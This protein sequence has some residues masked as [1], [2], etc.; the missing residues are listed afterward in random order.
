MPDVLSRPRPAP[1][2][3]PLSVPPREALRRFGLTLLLGAGLSAC[4]GEAG[5]SAPPPVEEGLAPPLQ[6]QTAWTA[7]F[8]GQNLGGWST[9]LPSRGVDSDPEGVFRVADG[10]LRVLD[11]APTAGNREYGYLLTS[12]RYANYRL[13]LQYRWD[14]RKFAPRLNEPRDS[15]VLYHVTGPNTL[16]PSSAEFQI[17]EGATGDLWGLAGTNFT[18]TVSDPGARELKHDPFGTPVTTQEPADGYRRMVRADGVR[19][20]AGWNTLELVVSGDQATQIVNGQV[21]AQATELRAPG[22]ASLTAGRI[23]LQAE[24]AAVS[25]REIELRPLA[26]LTPPQGARVLLGGASTPQSVGADWLDR[27]GGEVRWPVQGGVTTVRPSR[28]PRDTNDIQTRDT[29]GDFHLHLEFRLPATRAGLGEQDRANSGV[30]LQG[31]YEVQILDSF[32]GALAGQN[33]LGAIYGQH[34]ASTNAA[35]P[36][37][38]WQSYDIEFR[39]ARWSGGQKTEDARATVW[40]NGEKVQDDVALSGPTMLGAP[41]ADT[42]GPI[43]LQDH[44]SG[45]SFRNIWVQSGRSTP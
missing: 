30:Y 43:V 44:G 20:M 33:D 31:R 3:L 26:Y 15:G 10:E 24:G 41:E 21:A 4:A 38:T 45:V 35:L 12:E 1:R 18:S 6:P 39:A 2:S 32:G 36:S 7:L 28:D 8:N 19:E 27:R 13:R 5:L 9:W 22:G 14:T 40:L 37:G 16:W 17:M 23:A 25:Y 29:F 11:V 34:D 42:P